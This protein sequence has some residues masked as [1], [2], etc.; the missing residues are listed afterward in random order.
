MGKITILEKIK[1]LYDIIKNSARIILIK[2]FSTITS[3]FSH[4]LN[5]EI[6]GR[7]LE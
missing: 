3:N 5:G 2:I 1:C 7:I 6:F 4:I